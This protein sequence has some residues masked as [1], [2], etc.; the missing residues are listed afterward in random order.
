MHLVN[1]AADSIPQA[2]G[3][4]L[5]PLRNLPQSERYTAHDSRVHCCHYSTFLAKHVCNA[6]PL[7]R[8]SGLLIISCKICPVCPADCRCPRHQRSPSRFHAVTAALPAVGGSTSYTHQ[9]HLASRP[10][11]PRCRII[12]FLLMPF[13]SFFFLFQCSCSAMENSFPLWL[14]STRRSGT[15]MPFGFHQRCST[16][17]GQKVTESNLSR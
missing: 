10:H 8:K 1:D 5:A 12:C 17:A 3:C 7:L 13:S 15:K 14:I 16:P 11:N 4:I 9:H 6:R 2:L